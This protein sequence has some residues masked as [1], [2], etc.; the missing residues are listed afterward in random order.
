MFNVVV[1]DLVLVVMVVASL[2]AVRFFIFTYIKFKE[3]Q[4]TFS[5]CYD[6]K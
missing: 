6:L 1:F 2:I 5:L 3:K 4:A